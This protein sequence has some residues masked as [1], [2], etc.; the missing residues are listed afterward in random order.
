MDPDDG[1]TIDTY[2]LAAYCVNV[3]ELECQYDQK[4]PLSVS[5]VYDGWP[6]IL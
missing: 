6:F 4:G 5:K 1:V 3:V 2:R